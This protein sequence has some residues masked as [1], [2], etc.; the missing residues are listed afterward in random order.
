MPPRIKK[1]IGNRMTTATTRRIAPSTASSFPDGGPTP[2]S[3]RARRAGARRRRWRSG[4][5]GGRRRRRCRAR[6]CGR[7]R[8]C[9]GGT[10]SSSRRRSATRRPTRAGPAGWRA[11]GALAVEAAVDE[12]PSTSADLAGHDEP[13]AGLDDRRVRPDGLAHGRCSSGPGRPVRRAAF[14]DPRRARHRGE[15]GVADPFTGLAVV[16]LD[17]DVDRRRV[18]GPQHAEAADREVVHGAVG[19]DGEALARDPA[20]RQVRGAD[21]VGAQHDLVERVAASTRTATAPSSTVGRGRAA[22]DRV[23]DR[24]LGIAARGRRAAPRPRPTR[25]P[26]ARPTSAGRRRR[27]PRRRGRA[28]DGARCASAMPGGARDADD[29]RAVGAR[30]RPRSAGAWAR[31]ARSPLGRARTSTGRPCRSASG[32]AAAGAGEATLPRRRRRWRAATRL[33]A[34]L[35]P[36]RVGLEVGRLDPRRAQRA[37]PVAGRQRRAAARPPPSCAG[38]APCRPR[39][40]P[41]R[42]SRRRPSRRRRRARRRARRPARCRRRSPP[43]PSATSGPTRCGTPPSMRGPPLRPRRGRGRRTGDGSASPWPAAPGVEDRSA[44]PCTGTGGR[45]SA[46]S[47]AAASVA[48][49]RDAEPHDDPGRAEPALAGAG[50]AERV[51]PPVARRRGRRRW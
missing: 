4:P 32:R 3:R 40:A 23:D 49:P 38:P 50:G 42:A 33:A 11:P 15:H 10:P 26:A 43:R 48:A 16:A 13:V 18:D 8:P 41:R 7:S 25:R 19:V 12:P 34:G 6:S 17:L 28:G 39:P 36:R 22:G 2:R 9:G 47:T 20:E 14:R 27:P 35:A 44:S 1:L 21:A 37:V 46:R 5:G 30:R 29:A 24:D 31:G 45:A 51:G